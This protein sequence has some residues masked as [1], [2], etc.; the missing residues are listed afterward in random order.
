MTANDPG[1]IGSATV[2][3]SLRDP[4][5]A[6]VWEVVAQRLERS[7]TDN[8]GRVRLPELPVRAQVVL[9]SLLD[10]EPGVFVDLAA[11]EAGLVRLGVGADL[12]DALAVLGVPVSPAPAARRAARQHA[13]SAR[14][15]ARIEVASPHWPE[16]W[17]PEWINEVIRAGILR[18]LDPD[19]AV[20]LVRSVR[21]VLDRLAVPGGAVADAD[22]ADQNQRLLSRVELAA[23]VLGDAHALDT[24]TR[25]EAAA[26]R[27]LRRLMPDVDIDGR[28]TWERAGAHLDLISGP[29]L[30]WALP[31][32]AGSGL[33][34]VARAATAAG[35]PL[36][37]SQLALRRHPVEVP[38]GTIILVAENPRVVEAA[39]Q[40]GTALAVVASNGNP[41]HAGQLLFAQLLACG[42][43]LRYHGD[44]D[45]AGLGIC[46]RMMALGLSPWRM[47]ASDYREAVRDAASANV[48][49]PRDGGT[50]PSTPWDP[51][52]RTAFEQHRLAIHE[53]RLLA[54]LLEP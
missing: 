11:L 8:R 13:A 31:I 19:Q 9:R 32:S 25:L 3:G 39:V 16:P 21:A 37:L 20:S 40:R 28:A 26:T 44:F 42:A 24:G 14:D 34:P 7:G 5:M 49:L 46:A 35:V 27:A 12:A 1:R 23:S 17:A 10:R 33:A 4:A 36:H 45:T 30:T 15:A 2:P 18:D 38:R 51:E 6:Q 53:E 52:L 48:T 50:V 43:R 22:A 29:V 54:L 47:S 41:S